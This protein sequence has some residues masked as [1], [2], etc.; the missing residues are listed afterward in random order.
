M[1]M[2]SLPFP[3]LQDLS[4]CLALQ[5]ILPVVLSLFFLSASFPPV[6]VY[7]PTSSSVNSP[8][9]P[10]PIVRSSKN[11]QPSDFGRPMSSSGFLPQ[12]PICRFAPPPRP[13][14]LVVLG[15]GLGG[16]AKGDGAPHDCLESLDLSADVAFRRQRSNSLSILVVPISLPAPPLP[17]PLSPYNRT[18]P[19][20]LPPNGRVFSW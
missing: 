14:R 6:S 13:V 15:L 16:G 20:T 12:R 1:I 10:S 7:Q 8:Q 18:C 5:N 4:G 11:Y 9:R 17:L 19:S 2:W 3:P